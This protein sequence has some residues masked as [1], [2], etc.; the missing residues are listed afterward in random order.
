[1]QYAIVRDGKVVDYPVSL[2][3]RW[4]NVG[5]FHLLSDEERR[6]KHGW[7]PCN[8]INENYDPRF[9]DRSLPEYIVNP[10]RVIVQYTLTYKSLDLVK[11]EIKNMIESK[12]KEKLNEIYKSYSSE[13]HMTF[14]IQR[15]EA[16]RYK[17]GD[18][19]YFPCIVSMSE[20]SGLA[21]SEIVESIYKNVE[22]Y[23]ILIGNILGW[24]HKILKRLNEA[25]TVEALKASNIIN[26]LH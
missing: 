22:E 25:D 4:N 21:V 13:E 8:S 6:I 5:G 12:T 18:S 15:E 24:K 7:Y 17:N 11:I 14:N 26:E 2:I 16:Y 23:S 3:S 20:E 9:Q 10:T 19:S 1:M